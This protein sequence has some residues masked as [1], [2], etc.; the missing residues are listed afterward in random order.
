MSIS[1]SFRLRELAPI[2][3]LLAALLWPHG[4]AWA[5]Y[6]LQSGD[7]LELAVAGVPELRQRSTVGIDGEVAFPLVGNVRAGG[8][9]VADLRARLLNILA[10]KIYQ[11]RTSDGREV[12]HVVLPEE[13]TLSIVE[14][15]PIYLNGDV[16]RPGEQPFRPGLTVRQAVAVAGGY[17]IMRFRMNNPILESADLRAEYESLWTDYAREQA[18]LWRLRTELGDAVSPDPANLPIAPDLLQQLR[19]NE[20]RQLAARMADQDKERAHLQ[21]AIDAATTHLTILAGKRK[22]DED[23]HR[24]DSNEFDKVR[25]YFQR[26][27]ASNVRLSEARRAMLMS[28]TQVLQT[29][30]EINNIERQRTEYQRLLTRLD[31]QRR[32]ELLRELQDVNVRVAQVTAR[33]RSV[34]E[35]LLYTSTLQSQLIRGTGGQPEFVVYRAAENRE[36]ESSEDT[37]LFPGDTVFVTLRATPVTAESAQTRQST[38]AGDKHYASGSP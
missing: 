16:T 35:K 6:R 38:A 13:V 18:H 26:G 3:V 4:P 23:G 31:D 11:Q 10:S 21:G 28:S 5:A 2:A 12:S 15:R 14:Y 29:I 27:M 7:V 33:L 36:M 22:N 37:E 24:A 1:F 30:V 34:G 20:E 25:D 9:S 8:L 32:I 17:D 19:S